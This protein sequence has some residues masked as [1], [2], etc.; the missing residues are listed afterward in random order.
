MAAEVPPEEQGV[1]VPYQ[2]SQLRVQVPGRE[3]PIAFGCRNQQE[4]WLS[5]KEG[6]WSP[7]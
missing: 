1:S 4:L 2:A 7:T 6:F 3:V 5:Q